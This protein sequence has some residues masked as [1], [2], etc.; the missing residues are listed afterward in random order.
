M[1]RNQPSYHKKKSLKTF[2]GMAVFYTDLSPYL[3]MKILLTFL[4]GSV[5][6]LKEEDHGRMFPSIE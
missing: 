3:I 2:L 5:L 1:Q 4:K 6:P